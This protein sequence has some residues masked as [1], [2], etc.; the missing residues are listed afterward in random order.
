M[1]LK[2]NSQHHLVN[3]IISRFQFEM[4]HAMQFRHTKRSRPLA[5]WIDDLSTHFQEDG[6][7]SDAF[8]ALGSAAFPRGSRPRKI[9]HWDKEEAEVTISINSLKAIRRANNLYLF[10]LLRS[11]AVALYHA[12]NAVSNPKKPPALMILVVG[13]PPVRCR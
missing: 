11:P 1:L 2:I 4:L 13:A 6:N 12:I 9:Y 10:E 3:T 5:K 8:L 7:C